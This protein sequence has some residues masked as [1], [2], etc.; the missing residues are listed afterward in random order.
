M[1]TVSLMRSRLFTFWFFSVIGLSQSRGPVV[2]PNARRPVAGSTTVAGYKLSADGRVVLPESGEV[3]VRLPSVTS[4]KL[5]LAGML[6]QGEEIELFLGWYAAE[7]PEG[8][9]HVEVFRGKRGTEAALVHDFALD[10]GPYWRAGFL[11]PSDPRDNPRVVIDVF[12]GST[13]SY[14]YLLASD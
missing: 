6:Q 1:R 4:Q 11:Q 2:P 8:T 5:E 3:L 10:G 9:V 13:Y 7:G 14:T 12:A